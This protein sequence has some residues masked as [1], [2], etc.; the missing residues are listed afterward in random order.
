MIAQDNVSIKVPKVLYIAILVELGCF[1]EAAF[2]SKWKASTK[3]E[4][5]AFIKNGT[6]NLVELK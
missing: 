2:V 5:D 1:K 4:Y 6:W 3:A